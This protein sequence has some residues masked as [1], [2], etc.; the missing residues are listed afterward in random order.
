[1]RILHVF[2]TL[3]G[4]PATY[5][6]ETI[7]TQINDLGAENV[8]VIVPDAHVNF[9]KHTPRSCVATFK[10]RRR[11]TALPALARTVL[12]EVRAFQPDIIHAHS[13]FAGLVVRA[14][15]ALPGTFPPI[16]YC[17]HGWV[18]DMESLGMLRRPASWGERLL[19]PLCH[20]IIAISDH[21]YRQGIK[22]GIPADHMVVIENGISSQMPV[23][24]AATWDDPRTKVLFVGRLDRQ[25]GVDILLQAAAE[26]KDKAVFRVIGAHVTTRNT[27]TD[28]IPSNVELL[29][30][31]S[32]EDIAGHLA[33]CDVVAMPSR[34]EGFGLVALEAM[35]AHKPVIAS[36]VG[37]L[38][39]VVVDG[40][41]GLLFPPSDAHALATAIASRG[42][43]DWARMGTAG[44]AR[45]IER[46]RSERTNS[47]LMQLYR[48]IVNEAPVESRKIA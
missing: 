29:G 30:W 43:N 4:G 10:R 26:L 28:V 18:F 27:L 14:I 36:Q 7:P 2:E 44:Y 45:F 13:T 32:S 8:R 33:V 47:T 46:Y 12:R 19:S 20:T 31:K 25:K 5:A 21:E 35:R 37:G 42:A 16:V 38:Q 15:G 6:N 1:M 22:A 34:W 41:T 23:A 40:Q 39:S 48:T 11:L 9:L 17:P 3:P 24:N